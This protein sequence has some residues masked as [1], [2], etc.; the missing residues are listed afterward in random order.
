MFDAMRP[1]H[2]IPTL[3][4]VAVLP[5]SGCSSSAATT[6]ERLA[7]LREVAQQG[8]DTG[9]LLRAQEAP[10]IDKERCG[11]AFDGLTRRAD[12]PSDLADGGVSKEWSLQIREFFVD[13]CVSGKAKA[14]SGG[15]DTSTTPTTTTAPSTTTTTEED[16]P[17]TTTTTTTTTTVPPTTTTTTTG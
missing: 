7:Y 5:L 14:T 13:S 10:K 11:R 3:A 17:T 1:R 12:Y 6:E 8:A 2:A 15:Q 16:A 9:N 4:L